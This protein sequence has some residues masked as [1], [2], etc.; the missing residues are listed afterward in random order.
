MLSVAIRPILVM[1]IMLRVVQL[2]ASTSVGKMKDSAGFKNVP[3][4]KI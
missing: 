4:A 1:G 2:T 3:E